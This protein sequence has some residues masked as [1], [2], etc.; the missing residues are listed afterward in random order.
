LWRKSRARPEA[1]LALAGVGALVLCGLHSTIDFSLEIQAN[2]F[3]LLSI[4]ALGL[5][6]KRKR[7]GP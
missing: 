3:V 7:E 1:H 2:M 5:G 4:V 6:G